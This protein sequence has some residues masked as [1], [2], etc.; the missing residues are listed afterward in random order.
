MALLKVDM[1]SSK[2]MTFGWREVTCSLLLTL[3]AAI[4]LMTN[5]D[6]VQAVGDNSPAVGVP[7]ISGSAEVGETLTVSVSGITDADGMDNARYGFVWYGDYDAETAGG[8]FLAITSQFYSDVDTHH[9]EYEVGWLAAGMAISVL[10]YFNDDAGNEERL[11]SAPTSVV[12][13]PLES[14]SLV[15]T[16]DQSEIATLAE[17]STLKLNDPANGN[18]G[19]RVNLT[20]TST[21]GS[22]KLE[23]YKDNGGA[24]ASRIDNAKPYSLYGDDVNGLVG[25]GLLPGSYRLEATATEDADF[26]GD[27][28]QVMVVRFNIAESNTTATGTPA[29]FGTAQVGQTLTA[30]TSGISDTDGMAS[31]TFA[32]QWLAD[33]TEIVGAT[34]STYTLRASDSGKFIQVRVTFTDDM[35]NHESVT[36][37]ATDAVVQPLAVTGITA[38]SYAE[39]GTSTVATYATSGSATSIPITWSLTGNDSDDFSI[40]TTGE[41]RF[42]SPPDYESPTDSDMDNVYEVTV[43]AGAGDTTATLDVIVTVTDVNEGPSLMMNQ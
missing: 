9:F 33:D 36:S 7:T 3:L 12:P 43:N 39:N 41:L 34:S 40:S 1:R 24:S 21:V 22:V 10:V 42:S 30:D 18:Y 32:Y 14:F 38:T 25:Q 16:S 11:T 26:R 28:L 13:G 37:E 2:F 4:F 31:S 35:G 20:A 8:R 29:V 15:D 17:G 23:L 6:R 19:M 27:R 5:A